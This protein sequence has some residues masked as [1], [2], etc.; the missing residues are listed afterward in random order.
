MNAK[1]IELYLSAAG[2]AITVIAAVWAFTTG[3]RVDIAVLQSQ[4]AGM[5]HAQREMRD[6]LR[7]LRAHQVARQFSLSA[8]PSPLIPERP[9]DP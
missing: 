6:E 2:T 5:E 9:P 7:Q 1:R 3:I 4:T 8:V